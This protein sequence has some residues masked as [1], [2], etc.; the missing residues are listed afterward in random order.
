MKRQPATQ[1]AARY[2]AIKADLL[3]TEGE[4]VIAFHRR[5]EAARPIERTPTKQERHRADSNQHHQQ[6]AL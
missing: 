1:F 6:G 4:K 3:E 5:R 2:A